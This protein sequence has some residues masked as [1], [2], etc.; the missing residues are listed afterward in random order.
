M[1]PQ[2]FVDTLEPA[3]TRRRVAVVA[4]VPQVIL[5][6]WLNAVRELCGEKFDRY[7]YR[8]NPL[9]LFARIDGVEEP[10]LSVLM[11]DGFAVEP[12]S[13]MADIHV[14]SISL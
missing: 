5:V 2:E 1:T 11:Y 10:R 4:K 9:R 14:T 3:E 8:M 13:I 12:G 7:E 6:R